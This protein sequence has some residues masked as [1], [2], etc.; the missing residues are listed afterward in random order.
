[1]TDHQQN[2]VKVINQLEEILNKNSSG[3]STVSPTEDYEKDKRITLTS[4]HL[5]SDSLKESIQNSVIQPLKVMFPSLYFYSNEYLHLTIKNIR[6][7]SDPPN[8]TVKEIES[9]Q[10]IFSKVIPKHKRF[11]VYFYRLLL[12][13]NSIAL[14]GTSDAELDQIIFDLDE[15]LKKESIPDDKKYMNEKY[16]FCNITLVRFSKPL[17]VEQ[18]ER[19]EELSKVLEFEP[20]TVDTVTLVSGNAVMNYLKKYGTWKLA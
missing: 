13:P 20:Y 10:K 8:F 3:V 16:F 12:T 19:V 1:M 2:Q 4:I 7:I 14:I 9:A 6:V 5:P 17:T 18:K 11:T 15:E